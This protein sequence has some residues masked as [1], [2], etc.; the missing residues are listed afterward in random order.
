[1]QSQIHFC[2]EKQSSWAS[3]DVWRCLAPLNSWDQGIRQDDSEGALGEVT[4]SMADIDLADNPFY[5]EFTD[6]VDT[7]AV[8]HLPD[9][10][11]SGAVRDLREAAA[12]SPGLASV[13]QS[14]ASAATKA[15]QTALL[16]E[17][18][19]QWGATGNFNT[20]VERAQEQGFALRY[21]NSQ[22]QDVTAWVEL[23]ETF[24]G[25]TFVQVG[26]GGV[27]T[28]AGGWMTRGQMR[29]SEKR[30]RRVDRRGFKRQ[31]RVTLDECMRRCAV[32]STVALDY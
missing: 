4:G 15:E 2:C 7:S 8:A 23:L 16:G 5:R 27:R 3:A 6:S 29:C 21:F 9:M 28:G 22:G 12:L 32:I 13:L 30:M 19:N 31:V 10:Q 24:N 14:Y 1:M 25:A 26:V 11:G 20:S 18:L 17:L